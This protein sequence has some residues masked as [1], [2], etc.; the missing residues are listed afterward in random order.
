MMNEFLGAY[1]DTIQGN[2]PKSHL[3]ICSAMEEYQINAALRSKTLAEDPNPSVQDRAE[4]YLGRRS[5]NAPNVSTGA[6]LGG[7]ENWAQR[8]TSTSSSSTSGP[9]P[10]VI[11]NVSPANAFGSSGSGTGTSSGA[12]TPLDVLDFSAHGSFDMGQ[13]MNDPT[14]YGLPGFG[15]AGMMEID[16]ILNGGLLPHEMGGT[17]VEGQKLGQHQHGQQHQQY[18][19]NNPTLPPMAEA[20]PQID[21]RTLVWG[22]T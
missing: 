4:E 16:A 21:G 22:G 10:P 17:G 9:S 13:G 14:A 3:V 2:K 18:P 1:L 5:A 19:H 20:F 12:P 6:H 7:M 8:F 15:D 11:L